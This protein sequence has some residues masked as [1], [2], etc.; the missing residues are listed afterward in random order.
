MTNSWT[1]I[2]NATLVVV[3]GANPSENHPACMAHINNA[4][5][6]PH[7]W[8]DGA[9][10]ERTTNKRAAKL[11]VID[12]R[13]T[14]TAS[15][16]DNYIRIR[17]GTDI[18]FINAVMRYILT[19]LM[20]GTT[21]LNWMRYMN[22]S[23]N[24]TYSPDG[25]GPAGT[26]TLADSTKWTD[27]RV[28][29]DT[30]TRDYQRGTR[31]SGTASQIT[32]FPV[33]AATYDGDPAT[34]YNKMIEH[35]DPYTLATAAAI[36]GCDQAEIQL[37]G[38]AFVD[39]SRF[40]QAACSDYEDF[41][42]AAPGVTR[43]LNA[44]FLA[45]GSV[46]VKDMATETTTY[47]EGATADYTVN[48]ADGIV[49]WKSAALAAAVRIRYTGITNDPT[50]LEFQATTMLYAMGLTQHT[51]GSQNVK[52]FANLQMLMGNAGRPGGGINA[53]RGIHNVQGSTDMGVLQHLI[54]GYSGNPSATATFGS[55]LDSIY[56]NSLQGGT[57]AKAQIG[58]KL[59]GI[60]YTAKTAGLAGNAVT[61]A[62]V[63]P[64]SGPL[65]LSVSVTGSAITVNLETD[66]GGSAISTASA[67]K[68]A[69]DANTDAAALVWTALVDVTGATTGNGTGT[70][71]AIAATNLAGGVAS[72]DYHNAY[73]NSNN[74]L[75]QRGF[76][77][78]LNAWFA[79]K[80]AAGSQPDF[81]DEIWA[82]NAFGVWPRVNGNDHITM[83]R[84]M[85]DTGTAQTDNVTFGGGSTPNTQALSKTNQK[86]GTVVVTGFTEGASADFTIDYTAGTITR[87][88][89]GGIGATATV[90]V[91]YDYGITASVVW[92]MNPAV[93]EPNQSKVRDG[94]KNLDM[95]VVVDMFATETAQC[96]RK[97]GG[98]T[99]LIPSC[100]HVEE[101]G[102]VCNSGRVLQW[103]ERCI[104][105]KGNS[106]S[107]LELLIR[108]AQALQ[109]AS[110]FTH[111]DSALTTQWAGDGGATTTFGRLWAAR[112]GWTPSW[113]TNDFETQ[114]LANVDVWQGANA[115]PTGA[116]GSQTV[117]GSEAIAERVYREMTRPQAQGGTIWIYLEAYEERATAALSG[118]KPTA[119]NPSTVLAATA[120]IVSIAGLAPN[121]DTTPTDYTYNQTT[122][123][124]IAGP[125]MLGGAYDVT[126]GF[127]SG[128]D[129]PYWKTTRGGGWVTYSRA[130]A[131]N[132]GDADGRSGGH[133]LFKNWGYSWL[134]NRRVLYNNGE[135]PWDQADGFQGPEQCARFFVSTNAG[136]LNYAK[137]Y[138]T[139]HRMADRPD[140]VVDGVTTSPHYIS[141]GVSL[142]G[143]FPGH[144]E[145]YETKETALLT[146]WGRNTK[147]T[148][149]WDLVKGDTPVAGRGRTA[150]TGGLPSGVADLPAGRT[151]ADALVLTTIRCVEHFQGGPI[152]RNNSYNVEAEPVPWIEISSADARAQGISDGEMINV[153]TARSNSTT[154][155]LAPGRKGKYV[156]RAGDPGDNFGKGF[157]A[158]VG[159][160]L[161]GNQRVAPGVVAIPWH[162]G[163]QGLSTGSRAND[164]CIDAGDANTVIPEYKACLC[165]LEKV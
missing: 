143:S 95:L 92:G 11:I 67:V 140:L 149:K 155:Q 153:I 160:G 101:A 21:K 117:Y 100:A 33:M 5:K 129:A 123:V 113:T 159:V 37:V 71:A 139:I 70:V 111:I 128:T 48:Y 47:T 131:R 126:Y 132:A 74:G 162:W 164:L 2:G 50:K 23:G 91:T 134:V 65:P 16:A 144:T 142:A 26:V 43:Q 8:Y 42:P 114:T 84:K 29:V 62:Y 58:Q 10:V 34:V 64:G 40:S 7:K 55:Y 3:M 99:Y 73:K 52:S 119:A 76:Y 136:V 53:L 44:S 157:V 83:F 49:T 161:S 85:I 6:G 104:K 31:N 20:T 9:N 72:G 30:A 61:V 51:Y 13:Y 158:R 28:L 150:G 120:S 12:P 152:T 107:D 57:Y 15:Q 133:R 146:T 103:R 25:G 108:F 77:N 154:D 145:P 18:A 93:T 118:W 96:D 45:A 138:R 147:G 137:N 4:R 122:G 124:L 14:R 148:A 63:N 78:M 127:V 36:C 87:V 39:N 130:K 81:T 110:A 151:V 165:W 94:L 112:Y 97:T 121:S 41:T 141:G 125:S 102:S 116:A 17:P 68:G 22:W 56:G 59:A 105:P 115:A 109:G 156:A 135:V 1:D 98:V 69:I 27:A 88:G 66:A 54:P 163:E 35:L 75:Q 19:D 79:G 32:G 86:C 24:R 60:N 89:T 38:Q 106:K 90:S 82:D 80:A 46:T